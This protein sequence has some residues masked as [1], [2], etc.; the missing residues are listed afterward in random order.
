MFCTSCSQ[1]G[2]RD[3]PGGLSKLSAINRQQG[4]KTC[5][6]FALLKNMWIRVNSRLT[7]EWRG[8]VVNGRIVRTRA[9]THGSIFPWGVWISPD[10]RLENCPWQLSVS[11]KCPLWSRRDFMWPFKGR[12]QQSSHWTELGCS[13]HTREGAVWGRSR[14]QAHL[15]I[16]ALLSS[17]T[18]I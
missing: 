13:G 5:K 4:I 10:K 2:Y 11:F 1:H 14:S 8:E 3:A 6:L 18:V 16:L 15:R 12:R 9:N 7:L 17:K